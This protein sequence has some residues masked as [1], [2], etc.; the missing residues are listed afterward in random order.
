MNV[1]TSGTLQINSHLVIAGKNG[2]NGTV[3]IDAGTVIGH[4]GWQTSLTIASG[5][6]TTA[7]LGSLN[8]SGTR[9]VSS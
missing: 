3:N 7:A 4:G 9:R 8:M 1:N 6:A 2:D 5:N